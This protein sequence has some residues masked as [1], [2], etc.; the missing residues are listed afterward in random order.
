MKPEGDPLDEALNL[1]GELMEIRKANPQHLV[2]CGGAALRAIKIVSRTTKDVDILASRGE[3][4]GEI[5]FAWPLPEELKAAVADVAAELRLRD[6]WLNASTSLLVGSLADMPPEIW[7]DMTVQAYGTRLKISF[8]GRLG[9]IFLKLC[10]AVE[11]DEQRDMDDLI[12]LAPT[13]T[14]CEQFRKYFGTQQRAKFQ[15][16][17]TTVSH[18]K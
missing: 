2:V 9:M 5:N 7:R 3:V 11:R 1:L 10:A 12:A 18:G 4:D 13:I 14:E 15:E 8:I 6:D 17:V 16:I